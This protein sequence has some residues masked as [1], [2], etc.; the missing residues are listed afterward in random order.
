MVYPL[1]SGKKTNNCLRQKNYISGQFRMI[2]SFIK[3]AKIFLAFRKTT[4]ISKYLVIHFPHHLKNTSDYFPLKKKKDTSVILHCA[5]AVCVEEVKESMNNKIYKNISTEMIQLF[6]QKKTAM[7]LS[8][9][10]VVSKEIL[11]ISLKK[12]TRFCKGNLI[13]VNCHLE[14]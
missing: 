3:S 7:M 12:R 11:P 5:K 1:D 13:T 6:F 2:Q 10:S 14:G 9:F 8:I 4:A